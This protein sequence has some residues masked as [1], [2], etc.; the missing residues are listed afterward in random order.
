MLS[1]KLYSCVLYCIC[2]FLF[3]YVIYNI[4]IRS[5]GAG[6]ATLALAIVDFPTHL[7]GL[8]FASNSCNIHVALYTV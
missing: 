8:L 6:M 4:C 5:I 1:M 7:V 3:L 2:I